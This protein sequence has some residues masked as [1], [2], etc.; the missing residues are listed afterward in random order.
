MGRLSGLTSK[1]SIAE[2]LFLEADRDRHQELIDYALFLIRE[3]E[4]HAPRID[5]GEWTITAQEKIDDLRDSLNTDNP[6]PLRR[7]EIAH[8]TLEHR[9]YGAH[10]ERFTGPFPWEKDQ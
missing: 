2:A 10:L 5:T 1:R 9:E 6:H 3:H 8:P 7:V 4:D